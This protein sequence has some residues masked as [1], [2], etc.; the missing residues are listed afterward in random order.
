MST[1]IN[2]KESPEST[3]AF[4]CSSVG[5]YYVQLFP[6]VIYISCINIP[7]FLVQ[8]KKK[9]TLNTFKFVTRMTNKI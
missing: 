7:L 9:T 5:A 6:A 2:I 1:V 4:S 8:N 3:I